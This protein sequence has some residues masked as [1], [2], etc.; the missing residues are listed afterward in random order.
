MKRYQSY[1]PIFGLL[2]LILV[3][4]LIAIIDDNQ[5]L[6][7]NTDEP[8]ELNHGWFYETS[9]QAMPV[10]MLPTKLSV[11]KDTPYTIYQ[12]LSED[13]FY[14]QVILI[15]GSLAS[16]TVELDGDVI[17]DHSHD[18]DSRVPTASLW[19][20]VDVPAESQG[21]SISVTFLSPYQDVSGTLNPIIYGSRSVLYD[22]IVHHFG[23]RLIIGAFVMFSGF[24]MILTSSFSDQVIRQ[25]TGLLGLFAMV[26]SLWLIAESRMLQ[27]VIGSHLLIGSMAYLSLAS[28]P[29]PL[30]LFIHQSIEPR[31]QKWMRLL[32]SVFAVQL[33]LILIFQVTGIAD[34]YETV[35]YTQILIGISITVTIIILS[36]IYYRT[37][38]T[39]SQRFLK[40]IAFLSIFFLM[41][42]FNF[43]F[44]SLTN[45]SVYLSFGIF[46][47]TLYL[48]YN[49]FKNIMDRMKLSYE[50]EFYQRLAYVDQLTGGK[51]RTAFESDIDQIFVDSKEVQKLSIVY[52]DIDNLKEIN[53]QYGHLQ[54]DHYLKEAYAMISKH[55]AP[56]GQCYRVGGDEFACIVKNMNAGLLSAIKNHIKSEHSHTDLE[57]DIQL[58]LSIGYSSY[59]H[60][61][62]KPSDLIKRADEAMYQ[63]KKQNKLMQK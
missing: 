29:I 48:L 56:Y 3:F 54:G 4:F 13:F 26:L 27:F 44:G 57:L 51:N 28:F 46:L 12:T 37:K 10:D 45:V 42:I 16:V 11:D 15:R 19:H 23:F 2:L 30:I 62:E 36:L 22:D 41:E 24:I 34:F 58:S 55:Y 18:P 14:P 59:N 52:I 63:D 20:L 53:D 32:L 49:L 7:I 6:L 38:N 31:Y 47:L 60:Q 25:R 50:K 35:I 9:S 1:L 40:I 61:D 39:F 5:A 33:I 21:K 43:V 8:K 17:Y